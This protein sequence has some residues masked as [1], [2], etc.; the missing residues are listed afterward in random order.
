MMSVV[1]ALERAL[2]RR[3]RAARSRVRFDRLPQRPR[4]GL[5]TRFGNV[6][7]IDAAQAIDMEGDAAMGRERLEELADKLGIEGSDLRRCHLYAP[8]EPGPAGEVESCAHQR[9]VHGEM[10]VAVAA[11]A[12]LVAERGAQRL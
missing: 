7:G 10:T 4:D 3:H 5:E 12:G 8:G 2:G 9:I 11:D 1:I 6:V